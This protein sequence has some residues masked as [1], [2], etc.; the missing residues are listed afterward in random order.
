MNRWR[1][2]VDVSVGTRGFHKDAILE[3]E[4]LE[5]L[6]DADTADTFGSWA[7]EIEGDL[8]PNAITRLQ[9]TVDR[10]P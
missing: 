7:D 4:N 6:I 2:A 10:L 5:A 8:D 9:L 1:I 3:A